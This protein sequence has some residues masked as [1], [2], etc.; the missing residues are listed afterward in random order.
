MKNLKGILPI[1][2]F[3]AAITISAFTTIAEVVLVTQGFEASNCSVLQ[4]LDGGFN[5]T[6]TGPILCT[7][8]GHNCYN[9]QAHCIA[10]GSV[11]LLKRN[12]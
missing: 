9:T 2:A 3:A 6:T 12:P 5:C 10:D 11:G 8:N 7:I 4:A 1:L